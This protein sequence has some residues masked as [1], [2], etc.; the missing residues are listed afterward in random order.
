MNANDLIEYAEKHP[1]LQEKFLKEV[2]LNNA[3]EMI[4]TSRLDSE[5]YWDFILGEMN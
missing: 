2:G 4:Q 5:D 3:P 1:E